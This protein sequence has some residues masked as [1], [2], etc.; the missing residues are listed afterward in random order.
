MEG[1]I[2]IRKLFNPVVL[3][4]IVLSIS[5]LAFAQSGKII[6]TVKDAATGEPLPGANVYLEGTA[7]GAAS[8]IKGNYQVL[9]VPPGSYN[10]KVTFIGYKEL[11]Q[12]VRITLG[13][14]KSVHL[15]L[16]FDVVEGETVTITAQ[17]EG[18]VAAINQQL[19]SNTIK[20]VVSAERIMEL[21]D[22]NAA[23]SV[24]RLPGISLQRSGG[25]GSR[26]VIRGLSPTY[27][28]ITINGEKV[29]ATDLNDRSVD[30]NMIAPEMLEGIEVTKALTPDQDADA[31]GGTV[32]FKLADAPDGGF[33]SNFRFQEGYND[34]RSEF[35]QFKGSLMLS[36]RFWN[37]KFGIMITGSKERNQRGSDQITAG[38]IVTR[39]KRE[40]ELFAP[41]SVSSV[42]LRYVDEIRDRSG[43]SVL[44]DYRLPN[45][46]INFS[47]FMSRLDRN[48][49][50]NQNNYS[51]DSN[52]RNLEFRNSKSQIDVLSNSF[53]GEHNFKLG[54]L[55]WSLSRSV[56]LTRYPFNSF[57]RFRETSAFDQS[58]IPAENFSINVLL[59][60]A[61]NKYDNMSSQTGTF[62]T[63][64]SFERDYSA[65]MNFELPFTLSREIAG[66]MKMG[67]KYTTKIKERDKNHYRCF[68]HGT[69]PG[70]ARYHTQN[71]TPGFEFEKTII[72]YPAVTNYIDE[73]FNGDNFLNGQYDFGYGL[74]A[75]ELNHLM[76]AYLRDSVLVF[77]TL[78]DLNDFE[79]EEKVAA[80]YV[81]SEINIGR[82]FM[83]LPG[84]RYENT[85]ADMTGRKGWISNSQAEPTVDDPLVT[86]TTATNTYA[87]WFPMIH[88]RL[89][90]TNWFDVRLAYTKTLSRPRLDFML[91]LKAINGSAQ[92]VEFG[93]PDLKPQISDNYDLFLSFYS[94]EIGLLTFGGF[95]KEISDLIFQRSGHKILNA[96]EEGY[97]Y[98]L[99]GLFLD[100]PENNLYLTKIR[101]WEVEWQTRLHWLPG[102][103]DGF[104]LN[105]NYTH[106]WSETQ[107]PRSFVEQEKL[108]VFPFVKT[109]VIDSF[110]VGDMPDQP[111]DIANISLGYDKGPLSARLSML[112][113]GK[114]LS[115]IGER[116]EQDRY[117]SDL[118]RWDFSVKYRLTRNLGIFFN[119]NNI[120]NEADESYQQVARFLTNQEYYGWTTDLGIAYVF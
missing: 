114:T 37:D 19:R 48:E 99:Q 1:V 11:V 32:N 10:I 73:N 116:P 102:P 15:K 82:F 81:M 66:F 62:S 6:G 24:G 23:E 94:N 93:R 45:G 2:M 119:W 85:T 97:T 72:G 18:Q 77:S 106:I 83:L 13:E 88:A 26:V 12:P 33:H 80:G 34:Q 20:N 3:I 84:V 89:K 71:G 96:E 42:N 21:P 70:F 65:Q 64:K 9:R 60:A 30:L 55:D 7:I 87:R 100:Q 38:Y 74:D 57:V 111:D 61:R 118:L 47:N 25:E 108:N 22:V 36:N 56:S 107:F 52:W 101:G 92:R 28:T 63:D 50:R 69:Q 90:P 49:I 104:V 117:T 41:I 59:D 95:Y 86:D 27:N 112:Y 29:P 98:D 51:E 68:L 75:D 31:F 78:E 44:M 79:T 39:E 120:T 43:F 110:R 17:A 53:S 5:N 8:D 67:G 76:T 35:G 4:L 54:N 115:G 105:A 109:T 14:T 46:K 103:F 40:G 16:S 113:Q 91:P 58:L